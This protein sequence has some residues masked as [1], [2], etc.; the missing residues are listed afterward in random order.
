MHKYY[1]THN[2]NGININMPFTMRYY[3]YEGESPVTGNN[4]F[5]LWNRDGYALGKCRYSLEAINPNEDKGC[6]YHWTF[7]KRKEGGLYIKPID[8]SSMCVHA[9]GGEVYLETCRGDRKGMAFLYGT[10]EMRKRFDL[11]V[12]LMRR[13]RG[14]PK[15]S[16]ILKRVIRSGDFL[17]NQ[18]ERCLPNGKMQDPFQDV[19]MWLDQ[20]NI[21]SLHLIH[22]NDYYNNYNND[23]YNDY[24]NYYNHDNEYVNKLMMDYKGADNYYDIVD[25]RYY[26]RKAG[27]KNPFY[28][29]KHKKYRNRNKKSLSDRIAYIRYKISNDNH[30]KGSMVYRHKK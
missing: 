28:T 20:G 4:S 22:N 29:M 3:G 24:N 16:V 27:E 19:F 9:N 5:T 25:S 7:H 6:T 2:P 1:T 8:D 15:K 10:K 11:L 30:Y 17:Y 13:F 23:Y 26:S 21:D 14:D 12:N 18:K